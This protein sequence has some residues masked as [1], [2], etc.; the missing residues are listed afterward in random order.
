MILQRA[1][2]ELFQRRMLFRTTGRT[3]IFLLDK[4]ERQAQMETEEHKRDMFLRR[5]LAW[6][7]R[8]ARARQN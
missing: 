4:A 2:L 5:E 3:A 1:L 7:R 6:V 8:G